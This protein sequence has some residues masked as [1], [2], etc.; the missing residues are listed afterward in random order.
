MNNSPEE[1][2]SDVRRMRRGD[3]IP[4]VGVAAV[5]I[6]WSFWRVPIPG[7]NEPHYFAK[8]KHFWDPIWCA[9][10]LF[11]ESSNPHY[12]FYLLFGR[13]TQFLPLEGSAAVGRVLTL[14]VVAWGWQRLAAAIVG[15]RCA[16]LAAL[17]L[18][19]L[20]QSLGNWSGEWL[21]GGCESKV[22]AYGF[23]FWGLACLLERRVLQAALLSGLA[24]AFHPIVGGWGLI[25]AALTIGMKGLPCPGDGIPEI[26]WSRICL[27]GV[28]VVVVALPG[29]WPAFATLGGVS[30]AEEIAATH[31]QVAYRL[32]HHL[33]P[34][35]F[36][37]ASARYYGLLL[38]IWYLVSRDRSQD[39]RQ[40]WWTVLV[41]TA[42]GIAL[43]GVAIGWGPRPIKTMPGWEWRI[44][45]LK[46]YPF[47]LADLLVPVAVS[48]AGVRDLLARYSGPEQNRWHQSRLVGGLAMALIGSLVIPGSDRNP[49]Q[50]PAERLRAWQEVGAWIANH[51]EPDA[52]VLGIDDEWAIKWYADRP[53]YVN[54]KDCPQDAKSLLEWNRRRWVLA[55]WQKD[56]LADGAVSRDELAVLRQRTGVDLLIAFRFG[57]IRD[58]PVFESAP[59][60][61]YRLPD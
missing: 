25:A 50:M 1:T 54:Y 41:L 7:V 23:L 46:F 3:V 14:S 43:V 45:L 58:T 22:P 57:P 42:I 59:F 53:E 39:A 51:T 17:P 38:L 8:A 31:L 44:R 33:D 10:D 12:V 6:A 24:T 21:V 36:S 28:I 27:S 40:D 37:K 60:R 52:V 18:F 9:G 26:P 4:F 19:L 29:L 49:S 47:R 34:M 16:G 48:F 56:V 20:M 11:L 35:A 32:S 2:G 55:D 61:V 30:P 5:L 13:L 15:H